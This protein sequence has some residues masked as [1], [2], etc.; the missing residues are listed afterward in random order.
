MNIRNNKFGINYLEAFCEWLEN[1]II[2][3]ECLQV[4]SP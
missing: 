1:I 4:L 3:K 2:V